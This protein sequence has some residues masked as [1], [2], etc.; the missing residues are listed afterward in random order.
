MNILEAYDLVGSYRAAAELAGCDHHTVK[1]YVERRAQAADPVVAEPR[2]SVVDPYRVKIEEWVDRSYAKIRADVVHDKL[3]AMG[4]AGSYRTT[5]RAVA[6]LKVAWWAGRR[7]V[8]RPW[9]TEPGGWLQFDWGVGTERRGPAE[10]AVL[11]VVGVVTVPD[12]DPGVGPH[13]CDH[14]VVSG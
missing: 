13:P 9:I 8:Y 7:R 6:D 1:R 5:R 10:S 14:V 3:E 11:R 2:P 12:R 4:Y